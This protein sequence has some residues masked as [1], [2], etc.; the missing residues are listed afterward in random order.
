MHKQDTPELL[1]EGWLR[2]LGIQ[3]LS[4]WDVSIFLFRHQSSLISVEHIARLLGYPPFVVI[5][6]LDRLESLRLVE[7]SRA[8]QGARLYRFNVPD[9]T[10]ARN[11]FDRLIG[12]GDHRAVRL[13]LANR[14][15]LG[16]QGPSRKNRSRLTGIKG[17]KRWKVAS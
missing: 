4:E 16:E 2:T 7:R 11:A 13:H 6:S 15:R 17:G 12:V 14:A 8:S 3:C 5:E 1:M 9:G 10:S